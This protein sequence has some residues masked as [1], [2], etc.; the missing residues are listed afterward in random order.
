MASKGP[1]QETTIQEMSTRQ[2]KAP[3]QVSSLAVQVLQVTNA[4]TY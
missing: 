1:L 2:P 4:S 3:F